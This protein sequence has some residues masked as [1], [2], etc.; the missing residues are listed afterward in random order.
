MAET[1]GAEAGAGVSIMRWGK[2]GSARI[3]VS[4][5]GATVRTPSA[6]LVTS[7]TATWLSVRGT[8]TATEEVAPA[9]PAPRMATQRQVDYLLLLGYRDGASLTLAEA[10]AKIDALKGGTTSRSSS[11]MTRDDVDDFSFIDAVTGQIVR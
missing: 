7:L 2:Q 1:T 8:V 10:S 11:T 4:R 3:V 9:P 5:D 6:G